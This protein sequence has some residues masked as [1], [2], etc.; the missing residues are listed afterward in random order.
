MALTLLTTSDPGGTGAT[1]YFAKINLGITQTNTNTSEVE[2]GRGI[3][4]NLNLRISA[5]ETDLSTNYSTTTVMQAYVNA[6][7]ATGGVAWD[8]FGSPLQPLRLNAAG[9]APEGYIPSEDLA[10]LQLLGGL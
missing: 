10:P 9:D 8:A 4:A 5:D 1:S 7:I 6:Q 2:T 3:Y